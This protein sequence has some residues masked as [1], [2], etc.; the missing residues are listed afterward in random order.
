LERREILGFWLSESAL[1][2]EDDDDRHDRRGCELGHGHVNEPASRAALRRRHESRL[3]RLL[4]IAGVQ[5][6]GRNRPA[7]RSFQTHPRLA[8]I[9]EFDARGFEGTA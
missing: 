5:L 4:V 1:K 7:A 6:V 9:G 3:V 8:A 2:I